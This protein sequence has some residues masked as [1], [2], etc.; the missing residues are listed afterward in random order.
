MLKKLYAGLCVV[1]FVLPYIPFT[2][3]V[4]DN[5][6]DL[7]QFVQSLFV[8]NSTAMLTA[9]IVISSLVFWLFLFYEGRRLGMKN[10]WVYVAANLLVGL[11]LAL[12]LFL[13]FREAALEGQA[14]Y[15]PA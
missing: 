8:N 12:P 6:L 3:F 7:G 9:D 14:R 10:L 15:G 2:L 11:S 5:G 13:Y 4:M 1:G